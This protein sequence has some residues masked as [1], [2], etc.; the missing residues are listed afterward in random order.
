M[1]SGMLPGAVR[2]VRRRRHLQPARVDRARLH[3]SDRDHPDVGVRGRLLR[4]G[5]SPAS[6]SAGRSKSRWRGRSRGA[7]FYLTLLAAAFGFVAVTVAALL[8]GGA[9][10]APCLPASS[11]SSPIRNVPL[12]WLNGV[13]LFGSFAAIGLAASV[14]FDRLPPALGVT[15]GFVV[16]MYLLRDS[17]LA[18]AGRRDAAAVLAVP[19]P[20]SRRRSWSARLAARLR[21]CWSR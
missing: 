7:A 19:L 4:V 20:E 9:C 6:G 21:C 3:P 17:R 13:L 16:V 8:A 12:L 1:E 10:R 5:R 11:A 2:Q 18:V 14:S 15:L